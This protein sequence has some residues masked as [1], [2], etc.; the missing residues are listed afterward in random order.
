MFCRTLLR[1]PAVRACAAVTTASLAALAQHRADGGSL[2]EGAADELE[3]RKRID[4]AATFGDLEFASA[5]RL[6]RQSYKMPLASMQGLSCFF[7]SEARAGLAG[8]PSSLAMLPTFVTSRVTGDEVGHFYALDLGGT[9][10]RMLRLTLEG[11]GVVGPVKQAKWEF[12]DAV[13]KGS[14]DALF[15]FI[16]DAV[17]SFLAKECGGAPDGILGFTFS[18]PVE[19]T[20]LAAGTLVT[21]NKGFGAGAGDVVGQDVVQLL[22]A[23]L[24]ERGI[25]LEVKALANDTVG[26]MEAAAYGRRDTVMGVILGTGTNACYVEKGSRVGKWRGEAWHSIA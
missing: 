23:Q 16:A 26:T 10:F 19:Q 5:V 22:Q 25:E 12:P 14:G 1:H 20:A 9:N 3:R 8:R 7:K 24:E 15:G 11:G 18:F 21:W 13:K 6:V 17:A 2:C 4:A